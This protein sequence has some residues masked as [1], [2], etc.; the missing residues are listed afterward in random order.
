VIGSWPLKPELV[1]DRAI[2]LD[3]SAQTHSCQA[4]RP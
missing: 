2:G 4:C 1:L 3:H